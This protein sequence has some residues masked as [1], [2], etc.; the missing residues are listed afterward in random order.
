MTIVPAMAPD[1]AH[2]TMLQRSPTYVVA[3]PARDPI[4]HTL[5]KV[6]PDSAA[7]RVTRRKNI[8]LGQFFYGRTRTQPEK[9][10]KLMLDGVRK[11]LG[12]ETTAEH[13]TPSY[14]PW[15][16]RLCLIPDG[17][18]YKAIRS[19]K[20]S[21]VTDRI[22][23]FKPDGIVLQS[24]AELEADII[25]TATGLQLVTLGE[26]DFDVDG[27]AVDFS[28]TFTYKGVA[29]SDVPN[30][31]ST[32]GYINASWTL[33]SD[34]IARFVCRLLNHMRATGTDQCTPRLRASDAG[35]PARP[36]IEGFSSGYMQRMMPMLPKQ[37]DRPPWLNPQR[38][39]AD[40]KQLLKASVD[41]GVMQF[42]RTRRQAAA[43]VP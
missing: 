10:R 34:L 17:D 36:W 26:M 21:V 9:M 33:R 12:D 24:G 15:D 4:H 3:R 14:N 29:Y 38:Y 20:A 11:A 31:V 1:V 32:F 23:T 18:L 35:M 7:S 5:S 41:D 39:D 25:I 2:V 22:E 16:Q 40:R 37:G 42:T 30:L 6:L 27:E 19:G 28:R 43:A 8:A 13:F